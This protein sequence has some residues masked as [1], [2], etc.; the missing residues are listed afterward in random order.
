MEKKLSRFFRFFL[1]NSIIII[2]LSIPISIITPYEYSLQFQED[3]PL[4]SQLFLN[5]TLADQ[6]NS[7]FAYN[8]IETQLSFGYRIP[9]QNENLECAKNISSEM[10]K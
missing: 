5:T 6:F 7:S 4:S 2:S 8:N 3:K 10:Q 1:I 9:G